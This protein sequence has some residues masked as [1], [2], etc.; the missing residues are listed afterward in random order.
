MREPD[1]VP[2]H[3]SSSLRSVSADLRER[4]LLH[5]LRCF[6]CLHR[7]HR[8]LHCFHCLHS[9]HCAPLHR[10]RFLGCLLHGTPLHGLLHSF[11]CLHCFHRFHHCLHCLHRF[12]SFH[13]GHCG[14]RGG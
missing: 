14:N 13:G 7:F 2:R 10:G 4:S 5:G 1:E 3:S 11:H 9:F 12:H 8:L 6:H